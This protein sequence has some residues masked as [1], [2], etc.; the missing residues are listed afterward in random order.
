M[1]VLIGYLIIV[2][3]VF[4]GFAVGGGHL[5]ALFQPI[6]LVIIFGAALGAFVIANGLKVTKATAA[7]LPKLLKPSRF[8]KELH[9]ELL[10]LLY[11][12]QVKARKDGLLALE[13]DADDPENSE[14]FQQYPTVLADHEAV[15]FLTDY[16]R[17]MVSGNVMP[18]EM[19][20]LMDQE[21]ETHHEAAAIP[22][23]AVT[24]MADG[25]PGFGIVAAVMG[26]VHTMESIGLPPE[27]LGILIARA[28]VGTFLG[29]LLA[30]GFVAPLATL[31][32]HR[33]HEAT[34]VL[35]CI[36]VCLLAQLNGA[37]P[38]VA[39][40]FG[41]KVLYHDERPSAVELEAHVRGAH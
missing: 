33:H 25:L 14:V 17:L 8:T 16:L 9:M 19:E 40:E 27:E 24:R 1:W 21:L 7:E 35:Q 31:M 36:K 10:A 32:E 15:E 18:M 3:S 6:E 5:A 37:S 26:V 4:G 20:Q 30:Y 22:A 39:V 2:V 13:K 29:I 41:R 28:L 38:T 23:A 34:K 12:L 11:D